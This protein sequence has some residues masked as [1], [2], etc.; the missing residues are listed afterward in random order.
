MLHIS[1]GN[2]Y[3]YFTLFLWKRVIHL[4]CLLACIYELGS[5]EL[6][7]SSDQNQIIS[8][9]PALIIC[10]KEL[11]WEGC[12]DWELSGFRK[13]GFLLLTYRTL[14]LGIFNCLVPNNAIFPMFLIS[15]PFLYLPSLPRVVSPRTMLSN[16]S[17]GCLYVPIIYRLLGFPA[18]LQHSPPDVLYI[19]SYFNLS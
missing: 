10:G 3:F 14:P 9:H 2:K 6:D 8:T 7:I 18:A 16:S 13:V 15:S 11:G 19:V 1:F 5:E 17:C 12:R 4:V